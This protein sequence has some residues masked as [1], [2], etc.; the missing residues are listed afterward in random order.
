LLEA[1]TEG[2]QCLREKAKLN[3]T[4]LDDALKPRTASIEETMQ[5]AISRLLLAKN[6]ILSRAWIRLRGCR[7]LDLMSEGFA[8]HFDSPESKDA[9][10]LTSTMRAEGLVQLGAPWE[11]PELET[12]GYRS[13]VPRFGEFEYAVI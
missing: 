13:G 12:W 5:K 1:E 7:V 11:K 2:E 3:G 9:Q 10:T 8:E 6:L 4:I